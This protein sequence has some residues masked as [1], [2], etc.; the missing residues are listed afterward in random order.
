MLA[1]KGAK[2]FALLF[3][4]S[5]LYFALGPETGLLLL[6]KLLALS[7]GA[8]IVF[9]VAWPQARGIREGDTLVV[10]GGPFAVLFG[11]GAKALNEARMGGEVKVKL[12]GGKEAVGIVESYEGLLSPPK[13]KLVY[14][15]GE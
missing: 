1:V 14:E 8:S 7:L 2:V 3:A 10:M 12:P 4:L 5:L 9:M 11:L 15:V 6:A 13:I